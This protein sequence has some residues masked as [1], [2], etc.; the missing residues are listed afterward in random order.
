MSG[1]RI[2][3]FQAREILNACGG[4]AC[5]YHTLNRSH[6]E[7]LLDYA[8]S[9]RYRKP[10]NANG[11]RARMFHAYLTR[12]ARKL[13]ESEPL[14]PV[15]FR[16]DKRGQFKDSVTAVFPTLPGAPG[17]LMCYAHI[18]QHGDCS[19]DWLRDTR[20]A[21]PDEFAALKRELESAPFGYNLRVVERISPQMDAERMRAERRA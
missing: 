14:T 1:A 12:Q 6:V 4:M 15:L 21:T 10:R 2:D 18:G 17:M 13:D 3:P 16:A 5:D 7:S 20:P 9:L 19:R 11:S 8:D